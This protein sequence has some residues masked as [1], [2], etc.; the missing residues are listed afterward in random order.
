MQFQV[1]FAIPLQAILNP[2]RFG[3]FQR[4]PPAVDNASA[5][6]AVV[7]AFSHLP[8]TGLGLAALQPSPGVAHPQERASDDGLVGPIHPQRVVGR[9]PP[10]VVPPAMFGVVRVSARVHEPPLPVQGQAEAQGIG[11]S[12]SR[13]R[14]IPQATGVEDQVQPSRAQ[15]PV[16]PVGIAARVRARRRRRSLFQPPSGHHSVPESL[17]ARTVPAVRYRSGRRPQPPVTSAYGS[18]GHAGSKRVTVPS[19]ASPTWGGTPPG[20][21]T[22]SRKRAI[23]SIRL[24][25]ASVKPRP[26]RCSTS[27]ASN[28]YSSTQR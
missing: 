25:N 10:E 4:H 20:G 24:A 22:S 6:V 27:H 15:H 5:P 18:T 8:P 13:D 11:M 26:V 2:D 17:L 14:R 21:V 19:S 12:V 16:A 7:N 3:A 28:R 9:R 1:M 23:A